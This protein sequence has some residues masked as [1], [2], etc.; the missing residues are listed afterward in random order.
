MTICLTAGERRQASSSAQVPWMFVS[1]VETGLRL[2]MP[3][4]VWAA[5]WKTVSI[6][7]SPR[8]RSSSAWSRTSPRTTLTRSIRPAADELALRHPVADQ[9]DD[10]GPGLEQAADE[11]AADQAGRPGHEGRP[12]LPEG[13]HSLPHLPRGLASGPRARSGPGTRGTCPSRRRSRRGDRPSAGP[14]PPAAPAARARGCSRRR[15]G[16]RRPC[17]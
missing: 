17:G 7:Y 2:A 10:V 11:P 1:K 16:S 3:T 13:A 5:R 12:I 6:S 9:A 14:R 8:A 15:R 4:I